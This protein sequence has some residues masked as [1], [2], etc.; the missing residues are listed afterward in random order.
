MREGYRMD[1]IT[2]C[3]TKEGDGYVSRCLEYDVEARYI[4]VDY[5]QVRTT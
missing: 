4:V 1:T 2:I 3:I 5:S